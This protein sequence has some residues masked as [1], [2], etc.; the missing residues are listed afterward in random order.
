MLGV[1]GGLPL[2]TSSRRAPSNRLRAHHSYLVRLF[3]VTTFA[4]AVAVLAPP[5][6]PRLLAVVVVLALAEWRT[7]HHVRILRSL[8][9]DSTAPAW[10]VRHQVLLVAA[11]LVLVGA[12]WFAAAPSLPGPLVMSLG[13]VLWGG[14]AVSITTSTV[15]ATSE[16][17]KGRT[18][19][20]EEHA[21]WGLYAGGGCLVLGGISTSAGW[22]YL[23]AADAGAVAAPMQAVG[24]LLG[25]V[26]LTGAVV[27]RWIRRHESSSMGT[28]LAVLVGLAG[29]IL[30][31]L[32]AGG[33]REATTGEA[34]GRY[35]DLPEGEGLCLQRRGCH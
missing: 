16:G 13:L 29:L 32:A 19:T 11:V 9:P 25:V 15:S 3:V 22:Q 2:S 20:V 34:A 4:L 33:L 30:I 21:R 17:S 28:W 35:S 10:R 1:P 14:V 23:D 24:L 18:A 6:V 5:V 8:P 31:G 12:G 26:T 27:M 7:T